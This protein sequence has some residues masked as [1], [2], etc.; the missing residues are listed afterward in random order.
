MRDIVIQYRKGKFIISIDG[1]QQN[2]ANEEEMLAKLQ[3]LGASLDHAKAM[4]QTL[5]EIAHR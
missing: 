1:E 2:V 3:E 4:I 5:K